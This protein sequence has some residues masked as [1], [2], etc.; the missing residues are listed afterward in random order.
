MLNRELPMM[1]ALIA[2]SY[3]E[4]KER[5]NGHRAFPVLVHGAP[6]RFSDPARFSF[7]LGG[8]DRPP[9]PVPLKTYDESITVLRASL[10]RA[11]VGDKEKLDGPPAGAVHTNR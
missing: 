4:P 6:T 9:F 3:G 1:Q 5:R 2:A 11:K 10:D 7:S 8:K